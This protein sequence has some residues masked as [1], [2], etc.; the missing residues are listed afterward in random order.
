MS[1]TGMPPTSFGPISTPDRATSTVSGEFTQTSLA[2]S[3]ALLPTP[4]TQT[5]LPT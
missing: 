3:T 5:R 4:T 1:V 2:M